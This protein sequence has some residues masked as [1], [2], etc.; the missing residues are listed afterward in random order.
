M[1]GS[2]LATTVHVQVAKEWVDPGVLGAGLSC[3]EVVVHNTI[4]VFV[5]NSPT[6]V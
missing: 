3:S 4:Q 6:P 5:S 2:W 1:H